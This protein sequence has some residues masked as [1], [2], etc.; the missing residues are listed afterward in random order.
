MTSTTPDN[1][2][3]PIAIVGVGLRLPGGVSTTE[4]FWD[5]LINK[6]DAKCR[7]PED[8]YNIEAFHSPWPHKEKV[9]SEYGYFLKHVNIKAYDAAFFAAHTLEAEYAD[10]QQRL[11]LQVVWECI[12]NA[13][14]TSLAGSNAGVFVGSFGEDWHNMQH[15]DEQVSSAVR[16]LSTSDYGLANRLSYEL[17]LRGPR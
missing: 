10:P 2:Q 14:Q 13:G 1:P 16:V 12:E 3:E 5:L 4:D 8:R 7:V 6:R 17:D 11:L 15:R 9:A